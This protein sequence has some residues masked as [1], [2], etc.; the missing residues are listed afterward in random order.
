MGIAIA[1]LP[2]VL[3]GVVILDRH[4]TTRRIRAAERAGFVR[5]FRYG[6]AA[7]NRANM[8]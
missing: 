2:S 1:F 5:G 8:R 3:V 7:C 4:L 6:I